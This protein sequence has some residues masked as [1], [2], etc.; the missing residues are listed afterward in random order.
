MDHVI[1][2]VS[3][4]SEL[5]EREMRVQEQ[6]VRILPTVASF[7][8]LLLLTDVKDTLVKAVFSLH[9][10]Q[11]TARAQRSLRRRLR[12]RGRCEPVHGL[13]AANS[14]CWEAAA[15]KSVLMSNLKLT[16][17]RARY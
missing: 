10:R 1:L 7:P 13:I 9:Q 2:A 14:H 5:L 16:L 6:R 4:M 15:V 17:A 8:S 12:F 3:Y 11:P